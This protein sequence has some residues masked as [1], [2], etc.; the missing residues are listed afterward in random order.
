MKHRI[1]FDFETYYT[2]DY[3]LSK[4]TT[5]EYI[6][7]PDFE[8]VG[9]GYSV[10]GRPA[11]WYSG[12]H[13]SCALMLGTLP[14]E[15]AVAVAHNAIFDGAILE[16]IFGIRP[17][18]YLC[19]M[20]G[21]RPYVAPFKNTMSLAGVSEFLGLGAKGFEVSKAIDLHRTQF[22]QV[23]LAQYGIYCCNDVMLCNGIADM[24]HARMPADELTSIDLT[25]KKYTRPQLMLDAAVLKTRLEE[26]QVDKAK[27]LLLLPPG[28][29]KDDL[30]SNPKLA[31]KLAG[32]GVA[33]PRK[34]SK[35]TGKVAWAF[36]K[37]D[38]GFNTLL[39]HLDPMVQNVAKARLKWKSTLEESRL[40]RFIQLAGLTE[41]LPIPLLYYGA[42][43]G[44]FSG[45][46]S[47]NMQNLP[48]PEKGQIGMRHALVAPEGSKVVTVDLSQIEARI[49]ATLAGQWD[50][51]A[52]FLNGVDIYSKFAT[53]CYGYP[54]DKKNNPIERFV[55][56]TCIL[57]LGYGM[58]AQRLYD[59]L[60]ASAAKYGIALAV[61]M[62]QCRDW[63]QLYRATYPKIPEL[64]KKL[65]KALVHMC[66]AKCNSQFQMLHLTYGQCMLPN[67]MPLTY[68]NMK[69]GSDQKVYFQSYLGRARTP[70][71]ISIWGGMFLENI[72]QAL[73]QIIIK[74]AEL[75]LAAHNLFAALQVHD[76]LVYVV[77]DNKVPGV[78]RVLPLVMQH[79]VP[80]FA[81]LP[82]A[83][84]VGVGQSY[85]EAK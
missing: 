40:E 65:D 12:D 20:M 51:V 47:L 10:D 15:D 76:E 69:F 34:L 80:W 27:S 23:A 56:K 82:L 85:G 52:D 50:L 7:H 22:T 84:E 53:L 42:H 71:E 74:R 75:R 83:C 60:I 70:T 26:V 11:K 64:W 66:D 39:T 37:T 58:G 49:V 31:Q 38:E 8:V 2:K 3:S 54:C 1:A 25:I 43:T 19:T 24:L 77:P 30:M 72:C 46:D 48:R 67:G 13:A 33:P 6:L 55:G 28:I 41:W 32:M 79:P 14:W 5:A 57:G 16:W 81:R 59:T 63:V 45:M 62:Q 9:F 78:K 35:T 29:G 17:A 21:S 68:P 44:R 4:M 73:A 36:A 18:K 61:T